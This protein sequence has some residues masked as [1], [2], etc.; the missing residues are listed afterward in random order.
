MSNKEHHSLHRSSSKPGS[1][2]EAGRTAEEYL[3]NKINLGAVKDKDIP[4]LWAYLD[5]IKV[6]RHQAPRTLKATAQVLVLGLARL[7]R[8]VIEAELPE[9]IGL[10]SAFKTGYKPN[11]ARRFY[12]TWRDWLTWL[13]AAGYTNH[14]EPDRIQKVR[15]PR[16][17]LNT[18]TA[19]M[20]LTREEVLGILQACQTPRDRAIIAT[21]YEGGLR[22]VEL[23][24]LNWDAVKFDQAGAVINTAEKT[25]KAR[26]IRLIFAAPYLARWRQDYP[27]KILAGAGTPVFIAHYGDH[28]RLSR[29]TVRA[30]IRRAVERAG[31]TKQVHP[32]LFRH[33]R[34]THMVE[35]QIPESVI[36]LQHWG[37]LATPMLATY[38]HVT[39]QYIDEV[40]LERA[41]L[42]V[43]GKARVRSLDPVICRSCRTI[44]PPAAE[45]CVCGYPLTEELQGKMDLFR[46]FTQD[47]DTLVEFGLWLKNRAIRTNTSTK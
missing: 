38:T 19:A 21:L 27:G 12:H 6:Y 11:T 14:Y 45:I 15:A 47:P 28:R 3:E 42:Q 13:Y 26:Y 23:Y 34:I 8:P 33:T 39:N 24:E 35:D 22:P 1:R 9:L 10:F 32:Y 31:I 44:N 37:H 5:E 46:S 4:P 43:P 2:W 40:L 41:G 25:G 7:E 36:K 29:L 20:M 17:N 18:K 16:Q 30:I